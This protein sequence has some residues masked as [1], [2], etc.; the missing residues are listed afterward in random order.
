MKRNKIKILYF[1]IPLLVFLFSL[2]YVLL[3]FGDSTVTEFR[4][5]NDHIIKVKSSGS[6]EV[7]VPIY[8]QVV[9]KK[10]FLEF[11]LLE[12]SPFY[13]AS[14]EY[15]TMKTFDLRIFKLDN[16]LVYFQVSDRPDEVLG[17]ADMNNMIIYPPIGIK[18]EK[19]YADIKKAFLEIIKSVNNKNLVLRR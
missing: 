15:L 17:I 16:G 7:S 18:S 6:W 9:E 1:F 2:V 14:P 3:L 11:T 10:F 8:F 19:Y 12:S 4:Y 5:D 13:Y